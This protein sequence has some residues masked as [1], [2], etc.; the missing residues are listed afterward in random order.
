MMRDKLP[1]VELEIAPIAGNAGFDGI[2]VTGTI[3][4]L[5]AGVDYKYYFDGHALN[6]RWQR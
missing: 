1:E 3:P 6:P 5:T 4:N 2:S